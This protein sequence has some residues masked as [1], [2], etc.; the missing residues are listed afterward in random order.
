[1]PELSA[2]GREEESKGAANASTPEDDLVA[3][4]V[5][6]GTGDDGETE[7]ETDSE[8]ADK[9]DGRLGLALGAI[10]V[11]VLGLED[12]VDRDVSDGSQDSLFHML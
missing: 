10:D 11:V 5:H 7:L 9:G 1:M 2:P 4:S 6:D 3:V 12:T 8:G